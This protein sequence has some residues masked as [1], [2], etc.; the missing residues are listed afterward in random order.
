MRLFSKRSSSAQMMLGWYMSDDGSAP[1]GYHRLSDSPEVG[2]AIDRICAIISGATIYLMENSKDG[3]K[4]VHDRLSR[5]VDIDP[6]PGMA[7]RQSW[8]DWIV[9]TML[10]DGDG[11]AYV[12]PRHNGMEFTAL[13]PMPCASATE[14]ADGYSISWNGRMFAP[15]E[16]LHFRLHADPRCPWRGRGYRVQ[17][18]AVAES[19]AQTE[20][21]K[22]S[23]SSPKY[24]PP[25]VV[26]VNSDEDLE[27]D[28]KRE[29]FRKR[30]LED[31]DSGKPW[32][33]PADLVKIEQIKPLTL[34]DL[35]VKDT[36]E[37][38]KRTVA[39][40]F[41]V[42]AFL[43]GVGTFDPDEYNAFIRGVIIPICQGIEQE[44]TLKLLYSEKRYFQFNRRKLYSYDLKGLV[45]MDLAMSDRGFMNGDEVR[46]DAYRDPAGLKEFRVLEN[47]IPWDMAGT[48]KKL[49]QE[50]T[51]DA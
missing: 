35:C 27:G 36:V 11:N 43:L 20:K 38:D 48:Q 9:S 51:N 42:P 21:L 45:E 33:L 39:A 7:T 14:T 31:S 4:R 28:E 1:V 37:L 25:L 41:G 23:L 18:K 12:L 15:D 47:Y 32:I 50:G 44:L 26:A 8:M 49:K 29:S 40:I 24:K 30:F 22:N 34:S 6:W 2:A 13:Q 46:E 3:D 16:V 5:F 10:G 17:A 19:L